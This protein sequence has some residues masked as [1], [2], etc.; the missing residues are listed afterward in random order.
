MKSGWEKFKQGA[1]ELIKCAAIKLYAVQKEAK[2][3][4]L[5]ASEST[6]ADFKLLADYTELETERN[7]FNDLLKTRAERKAYNAWRELAD[8][9][10][11]KTSLDTE[12]RFVID[13]ENTPRLVPVHTSV[14]D[15]CNKAVEKFRNNEPAVPRRTAMPFLIAVGGMALAAGGIGY[16][17]SGYSPPMPDTTSKPPAALT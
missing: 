5:S 15:W 14:R 11:A 4:I 8:A 6:L 7:S 12:I 16:G 1:D 2:T 10:R 3:K 13:D 17:R 9:Y